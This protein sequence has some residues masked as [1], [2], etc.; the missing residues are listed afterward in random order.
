MK[1]FSAAYLLV[2][3]AALCLAAAASARAQD[4]FGD[5]FWQFK[6]SAGTDY[7]TGSYGASQNT[8][9]SYSYA[10][11]KAMRGPWTLKVVVPWISVSG[12]AVLLDAGASGSV[13]TLTSRNASGQGDISVAATYSLEQLYNRGLFVDFTARVKIPTASF[14]KGLGTGEADGALQVDV[15]QSMGRF[16]PFITFGYKANG[17]PKGF[18]LRD[19][20]YG[21]AGLQY[22]FSDKFAAGAMFDY[23]QASLVLADDPREATFYLNYKL[24][25]AWTINVYGVAGFS[26]NSPSAGGGTVITYKW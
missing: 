11:L 7:S 16:M 24:A 18:H 23:R 9:V 8:D 19:V 15:A 3:A 22:N 6:A 14:S 25:H 21:T 4:S 26:R 12:P 5:A 13:G 2:S 1:V 17:R 10:A 20:V